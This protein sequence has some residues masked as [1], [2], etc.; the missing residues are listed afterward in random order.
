MIEITKSVVREGLQALIDEAGDEFVYAPVEGPAGHNQCVYVDNGAPS[1]IVGRFL[2]NLGVTVE[3]L[4]KADEARYGGGL[5]AETLLRELTQEEVVSVW[6][7][8]VVYA[9][10]DAQSAQDARDSWG[11]AVRRANLALDGE[12]EEDLF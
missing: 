10:Q 1:C 9:L 8:S 3:R 11:E 4:K 12:S 7:P 2:V 5:S 6:D